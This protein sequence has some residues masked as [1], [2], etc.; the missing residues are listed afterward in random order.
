MFNIYNMY[1]KAEY[2]KDLRRQM[3][4]D[5][6]R[7]ESQK[8]AEQTEDLETSLVREVVVESHKKRAPVDLFK[9]TQVETAPPVK[10]TR[11]PDIDLEI[12]RLRREFDEKR[13]SYREV[14]TQL[15]VETRDY[16]RHT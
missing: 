14:L 11:I 10:T 3:E 15:L 9:L 2:A 5:R 1:D 7:R 12:D 6:I 4:D 8:K 13:H 16:R